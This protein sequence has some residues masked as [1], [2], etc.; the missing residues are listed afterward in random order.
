VPVANDLADLPAEVTSGP[1]YVQFIFVAGTRDQLTGLR[2]EVDCYGLLSG[3]E[4]KP[5]H[6]DVATTI[7]D[8]ALEVAGAERLY[9]QPLP[10]AADLMQRLDEAERQDKLVAIIV[11]TWTL[12]LP[13]YH[14]FMRDY[15]RRSFLNCVVLVPWNPAHAD[16]V[17]SRAVLEDAI[18]ATFPSRTAIKDPKTFVDTIASTDQL[19]SSLAMSL[20]AARARVINAA[21]VRRRAES[22]QVFVKPIISAASGV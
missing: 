15:D 9:T 2:Q 16:T 14:A 1:R 21:E 10:L 13:E 22:G 17:G 7:V 12:R 18:R 19:R 4:W 3:E 6:P 8:V 20:A 5:Y 11:D